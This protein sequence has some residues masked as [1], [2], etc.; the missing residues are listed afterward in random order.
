MPLNFYGNEDPGQAGT[1]AGAGAGAGADAPAEQEAGVY[2][3]VPV[4]YFP[5]DLAGSEELVGGFLEGFRAEPDLSEHDRG[6]LIDGMEVL[7]AQL[8]AVKDA[9]GVYFAYGMHPDEKL[10]FAESYLALYVREV[11]LGNPR[12]VLAGFAE[13][14]A[15]EST[16]RAVSARDFAGGRGVVAEYERV[17]AAVGTERVPSNEKVTLHQLQAAFATPD[18]N[19]I[20]ILELTSRHTHLWESYRELL[21]ATADTVTF[22]APAL[23]GGDESAADGAPG[24][25]AAS[26]AATAPGAAAENVHARM[27][28]LLG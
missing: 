22:E 9:G 10:G 25:E 18:G 1:G 6:L 17:L 11:G 15:G 13:A 24:P 7:D 21:L 19:R 4:G 16:A 3:G 12:A 28:R 26:A 8:N 2:F 20:A 27:N 14:A 23:G 5:I